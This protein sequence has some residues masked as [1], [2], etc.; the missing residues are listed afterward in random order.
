MNIECIDI[1]DLRILELWH[2][3]GIQSCSLHDGDDRL[4]E[5]YENEC[6]IP[7]DSLVITN[8]D[9]VFPRNSSALPNCFQWKEG[10]LVFPRKS[11]SLGRLPN[12]P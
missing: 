1:I 8:R 12:V 3:N 7:R 2:K 9:P 6:N 10:S 4:L 5:S 11:I